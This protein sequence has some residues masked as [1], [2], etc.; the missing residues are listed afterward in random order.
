[1]LQ[2]FVAGKQ[3]H[4]E[5]RSGMWRITIG[6]VHYCSQTQDGLRG[7]LAFHNHASAALPKEPEPKISEEERLIKVLK[8]GALPD[9]Q[10]AYLDLVQMA[11][12]GSS[13]AQDAL[14]AMLTNTV[15]SRDA[16]NIAHVIGK[17]F[18]LISYDELTQYVD[19]I[20]LRNRLVAEI[21]ERVKL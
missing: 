11:Q 3:V 21:S 9:R 13:V 10:E 20:V 19:N 1:M 4:P 2:F 17:P 15:P 8:H 18:D 14:G 6:D 12:N 7:A 5:H 16:R